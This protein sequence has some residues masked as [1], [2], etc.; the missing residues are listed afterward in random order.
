MALPSRGQGTRL[1]VSA[2]PRI[3]ANGNWRE[4]AFR[5]PPKNVASNIGTLDLCYPALGVSQRLIFIN[6]LPRKEQPMPTLPQATET[7]DA[8]GAN[9]R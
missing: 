9:H 7:W 1:A 3:S 4:S 2:P 5:G 6:P 8:D